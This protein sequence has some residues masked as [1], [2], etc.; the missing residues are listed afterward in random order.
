MRHEH[1]SYLFY[2]YERPTFPDPSD[3]IHYD[4]HE[5]VETLFASLCQPF[6]VPR[7]S[8]HDRDQLLNISLQGADR[9]GLLVGTYVGMSVVLRRRADVCV[10]CTCDVRLFSFWIRSALLQ[11]H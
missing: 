10:Y 6:F 9:L 8:E 11:S 3:T 7:T 1:E 4:F 5:R 2:I